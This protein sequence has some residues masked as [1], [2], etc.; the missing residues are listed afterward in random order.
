MSLIDKF[1]GR[2]ATAT[3]ASNIPAEWLV[4]MND[5]EI[6]AEFMS[7]NAR[8]ARS[9][10]DA[11]TV[12]QEMGKR[13]LRGHETSMMFLAMTQLRKAEEGESSGDPANKAESEHGDPA[14]DDSPA[15]TI[16]Y[17]TGPD[18]ASVAFVGASL[19]PIDAARNEHI[20]GPAGATL[21]DLYLSAIGKSREEVV[22][23]SIVPVL[24]RDERDRPREPTPEEV[25]EHLPHFWKAMSEKGVTAVVALG[26][27]ARE[28]LGED[29]T[30]WVPH[31]LAV[32]HNSDTGE[33][34]RK[35]RKLRGKLRRTVDGLANA[36]PIKKE[37]EVEGENTFHYTILWK[38][39]E[40]Q[41]ITGVVMEP[42]VV[43]TQGDM[44]SADEIEKAAHFYLTNSRV[45]GDEHT[46]IADDVEVV[47][48]YLA[49]DDMT[50]EGQAVRKGSW[51][52]TVHVK[53][54]DRWA[55]VKDGKYNGFSIG[56]MAH[57]V[58]A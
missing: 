12:V 57:R 48:S 30:M 29:A 14:S 35:L 9:I 6:M 8:F 49:P 20:T 40:K 46:D 21:R 52:M 16:P 11:E 25:Q 1:R 3:K 13:G 41:L 2:V 55:E 37:V 28:S 42:D 53:S 5:E 32:R 19:S 27:T 58:T 15:I 23:A 26:K 38:S 45:V 18:G 50:L 22:L 24:L 43:D 36:A 10:E 17:A 54:S 47:E 51:L 33:V 31:P 4:T 7:L 44:T 56:A 34:L 39:D